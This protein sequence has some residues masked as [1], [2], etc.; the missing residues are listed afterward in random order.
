MSQDRVIIKNLPTIEEVSPDG[1]MIVE[2]P[3]EGFGTY[4][5]KIR[6]IQHATIAYVN[7]TKDGK[8]ITITC[9][10]IT[11]ETSETITEPTAKVVD[12]G[13]GTCT[14]TL[15]DVDGQTEVTILSYPHT[16]PQPTPGSDNFITSGTLYD[17]F[18]SINEKLT[19][20][21]DAVQLNY[22]NPTP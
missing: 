22:F 9:R 19:V 8:V 15:T 1:Y 7:I 2:T 3:D 18:T 16:D 6:D 4:K 11:G 17:I 20:L 14:F 21:Q 5:A 12:N 13:D 10:D